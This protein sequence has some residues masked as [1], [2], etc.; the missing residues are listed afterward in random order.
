M[1]P[2]RGP[3][4]GKRRK[5]WLTERDRHAAN[6]GATFAAEHQG[7]LGFDPSM[8]LPAPST[9]CT[10]GAKGGTSADGDPFI[11]SQQMSDLQDSRFKEASQK[12]WSQA[13]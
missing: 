4:R 11:S 6:L 9:P 1:R 8:D 12:P 7:D 2:R 13:T 3:P 5:W 10:F